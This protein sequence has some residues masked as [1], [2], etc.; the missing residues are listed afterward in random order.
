MLDVTVTLDLFLVAITLGIGSGL[1]AEYVQ[2]LFAS[3]LNSTVNGLIGLALP[4][5][6]GWVVWFIIGRGWIIVC[7]IVIIWAVVAARVGYELRARRATGA[8]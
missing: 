2:R 7:I 3:S 5:A 1:I 8:G 4:A 6:T